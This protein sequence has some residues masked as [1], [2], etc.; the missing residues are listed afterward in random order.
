MEAEDDG[1]V[2]VSNVDQL[3]EEELPPLIPQSSAVVQ[4]INKKGLIP[5]PEAT[6]NYA[7]SAISQARRSYRNLQALGEKFRTI[8][9]DRYKMFADKKRII[10]IF[11]LGLTEFDRTCLTNKWDGEGV[12]RGKSNRPPSNTLLSPLQTIGI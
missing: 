4:S 8:Y 7:V 11:K 9:E 5:I 6:I 10:N 1:L 12:S 3:Q 2:A